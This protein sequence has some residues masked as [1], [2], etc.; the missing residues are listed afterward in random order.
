MKNLTTVTDAREEKNF[1]DRMDD[2]LNKKR[3]ARIYEQIK[4]YEAKI[5]EEK[6]SII[7]CVN[8]DLLSFVPLKVER[9]QYFKNEIYKLR[10]S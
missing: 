1:Q 6:E 10:N 5:E 7:D 3:A 2:Y 9:I 8:Q 4:Y